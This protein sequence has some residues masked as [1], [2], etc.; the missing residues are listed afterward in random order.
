MRGADR[1][2]QSIHAACLRLTRHPHIGRPVCPRGTRAFGIVDDPYVVIYKVLGQPE[3]TIVILAIFH[4]A[5]GE[6]KL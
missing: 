6:R 1:A 4:T 3:D 5:Q 2:G